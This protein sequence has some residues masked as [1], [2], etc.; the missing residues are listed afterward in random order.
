MTYFPPSTQNGTIDPFPPTIISLNDT[1]YEYARRYGTLEDPPDLGSIATGK[2]AILGIATSPSFFK[3]IDILPSI[4]SS[5]TQYVSV[6][7][8]P[9]SGSNLTKTWHFRADSFASLNSSQYEFGCAFTKTG[10]S[11]NSYGFYYGSSVGV[12]ST[13]SWGVFIDDEVSNYFDDLVLVGK[14]TPIQISGNTPIVQIFNNNSKGGLYVQG[15][16]DVGGSGDIGSTLG[17]GAKLT[18]R[19]GGYSVTGNSDITGTLNVTSTVTAPTFVGS[20]TGTASGNKTLAAFDIPH[21]TK[22]GKRIRHVVAEGPEP[23]I[24]IRGKLINSNSIELP[25]Y[26][27]GLI[28]PESITVSLTQIGYSQDLIVDGIE[29]GKVVKIKS[30]NGSN[31]NCY[32]EVWAARWVNP[33]D[34]DE[35]LHVVYEGE[36]PD[37]YPGNRNSFLVGGWDYDKRIPKWG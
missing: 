17:V 24:Y 5:V 2:L 11:G 23:G 36:T 34:H 25:E 8:E 9:S 19:S 37:D 3:S 29:W 32:Y 6:H 21:V 7:S 26:W 33:M 12:A 16:A 18:V 30:G 35:K 15:N 1:E 4:G 10:S 27:D 22:K 14:T 31:I 28:D 20:L 13:G